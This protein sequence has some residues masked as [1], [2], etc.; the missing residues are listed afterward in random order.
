[1]GEWRA[2]VAASVQAIDAD[3]RSV[4]LVLEDTDRALL[5]AA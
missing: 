3:A 4:R 5:A 1:M 2:F